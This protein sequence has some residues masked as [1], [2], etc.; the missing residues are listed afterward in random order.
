MCGWKFVLYRFR[1]LLLELRGTYESLGQGLSK[2]FTGEGKH[3]T[4]P[5]TK[6]VVLEF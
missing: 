4:S 6:Y 5:C 3:K 1:D 2:L